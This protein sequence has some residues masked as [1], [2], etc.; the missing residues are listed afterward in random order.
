MCPEIGLYLPPLSLHSR[1]GDSNAVASF[2]KLLRAAAYGLTDYHYWT[3]RHGRPSRGSRE[4][5]M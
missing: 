4:L 1:K 3:P 2:C 5:G